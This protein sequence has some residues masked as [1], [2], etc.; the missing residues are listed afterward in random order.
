MQSFMRS[1]WHIALGGAI[2]LLAFTPYYLLAVLVCIAMAAWWQPKGT[3]FLNS[4][5]TRF[6]V[7]FLLFAATV[8][9]VGMFCW[10]LKVVLHPAFVFVAYG[11]LMLAA[12]HFI[13]A[14]DEKV[15]WFNTSDVLAISTT[16]L[17]VGILAASF[18]FP[19]PSLSASVQLI[20]NGFDHGAH[21]SMIQSTFDPLGYLYGPYEEIKEKIAW[22]TLTAYPQGWHLANAFMWNGTGLDIFG[23]D[24]RNIA[25]NL[26]AFTVMLW[27]FIAIFLFGK[28]ALLF[29]NSIGFTANLRKVGLAFSFVV[30]SGLVQAVMFWGSMYFGFA[31]FIGALAYIMLLT[32]LLH[33][34]QEAKGKMV[35]LYFGLAGMAV[36]AIGLVWL[37]PVIASVGMLVLAATSWITW[38]NAK[39]LLGNTRQL[40]LF[41]L[42]ALGVLIPIVA[43]MAVSRLYTTQENQIN[44]HGGIYGVSSMLV[45]LVVL[46]AA[47]VFLRQK[48][49]L[50]NIFIAVVG[51]Q[52][53]L[54]GLIYLY[55]FVTI[56]RTEYFFTKNM[57]LLLCLAG[58]FF[59]AG[60]LK[61]LANMK[62]QFWPSVMIPVVAVAFVANLIILSGQEVTSVKALFQRSSQ[63]ETGTAEVF[64]ELAT[65]GEVMRQQ[66]IFLTQVDYGGDINGNVL[67]TALHKPETTCIGGSIWMITDHRG[68]D[69]PKQIDMCAK[70][71]GLPITVITS[72][73]TQHLF[74]NIHNP[75]ITTV[76]AY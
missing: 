4:Y 57:A 51:P 7:Q 49:R 45:G 56:G 27:Q 53:L 75:L 54:A 8:M 26:Y 55:Q 72:Q 39:M 64:A 3:S 47:A 44:D 76:V 59:V 58:V 1:P 34:T 33:Q 30:L 32:A 69:F 43:M 15:T 19:Q 13:P 22:S 6:V 21:L 10:L 36:A 31:S 67:S 18:Y 2:L 17:G 46:G 70:Q 35:V 23:S 9:I 61:L 52:V 73:Q 62:L 42:A 37:L 66:V 25:L 29:A 11:G 65:N 48:G 12:A 40:A 38:S 16:L 14:T 68:K 60:C 71:D 74:A 5:F 20:T 41:L 50:Q 28:A 24:S 63:L